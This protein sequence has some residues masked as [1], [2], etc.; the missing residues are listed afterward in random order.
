MLWNPS[1]R[2]GGGG[3]PKIAEIARNPTP[4][5]QKRAFR[6]PGNRR[7]R[8]IK[9]SRLMTLIR[10][11][12]SG[13]QLDLGQQEEEGCSVA[14]GALYADGTAVVEDDVLDD[15]QAKTRAAAFA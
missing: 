1:W 8:K 6:G 11:R 14:Y 15:C 4:E 13:S 10:N 9:T 12:G 3:V 7:D 2:I 5:S